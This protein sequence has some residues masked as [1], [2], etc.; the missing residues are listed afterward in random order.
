MTTT[1]I[2]F[3]LYIWSFKNLDLL[4]LHW[5]IEQYALPTGLY[6]TA[7]EYWFYQLPTKIASTGHYEIEPTMTLFQDF[8]NF[9]SHNS[10]IL[11]D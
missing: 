9:C 3:D 4:G 2:F 5:T 8:E 10:T 1:K 6:Y 7:A 11:R